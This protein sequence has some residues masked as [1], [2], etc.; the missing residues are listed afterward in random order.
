ML[1][2]FTNYFSYTYNDIT[3]IID[4]TILYLSQIF[5]KFIHIF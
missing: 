5:T 1:L 4:I 3:K 2:N